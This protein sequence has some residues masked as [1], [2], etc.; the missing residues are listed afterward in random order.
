VTS[1]AV[2]TVL[3]VVSAVCCSPSDTVKVKVTQV[4]DQVVVTPN[5]L[6]LEV[7][8]TS[9][10]SA[11]VRDKEGQTITGAQVSWSSTNT[12]VGTVSSS[13]L[14][15]AQANGTASIEAVSDGITGTAS[16]TVSE[17]PSPQ[18]SSVTLAP[19][20]VSFTA[21]EETVQLTATARNGSGEVVS[22]AEIQ[23]SSLNPSVATVD[24][25]GVVTSK[26]LGQA[27][28]VAASVC[29]SA[30][31][32][33]DVDVDQ[34]ATEI[35]VTPTSLTLEIG[36]SE[37]LVAVVKDQ[38]GHE[39]SN[40]AIT[41]S[42][43]NTYVATVSSAG[44]VLAKAEGTVTIQ[45]QSGNAA[46]ESALDVT[47]EPLPGTIL[48]E[49][50]FENGL[51]GENGFIWNNSASAYI[52]EQN[53]HSGAKHLRFTCGP[54]PAGQ[55]CWPEQRFD[56][57]QMLEE[58]WFEYYY[59]VPDNYAH[60]WDGAANNKFFILWGDK[61]YENNYGEQLH[62]WISLYP[63]ATISELWVNEVWEE[64]GESINIKIVK[65]F[66]TPEMRGT[67]K[68]VRFHFKSSTRQSPRDG[69]IEMW[70]DDWKVL[71]LHNVGLYH[72]T[73]PGFQ[74]GYFP[75][76]SNSGFAQ[77]THFDFDDFKVYTTDPG[78]E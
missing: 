15:T 53:P 46:G 47:S 13:G 73:N 1:R 77:Q 59:Y 65:G 11:T 9:Q 63:D 42:S 49:T 24:Q 16:L 12:S 4:A 27:L 67:W 6:S 58:V 28:I 8:A 66:I 64:Q 5:Q 71:D 2:G 60:R 19:E 55:D 29:C 68:R 3:I 40:P 76:W 22:G 62:I 48:Y 26:S 17:E 36:E 43:N 45:A 75:G 56:M 50:S 74:K 31:D 14:V 37:Q 7:G 52:S 72:S 39:I 34:I 54:N 57:G 35:S 10:L 61:G 21:L 20:S 32:T 44:L 41:W 30:A 70:W 18:V 38:N 33:T 78:W 51:V 25:G 23:W 69:V